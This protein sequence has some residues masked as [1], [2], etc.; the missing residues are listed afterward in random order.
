MTMLILDMTSGHFIEPETDQQRRHTV[1]SLQPQW[2]N[3]ETQL[4]VLEP[5]S[6]E[7]WKPSPAV[8]GAD[9]DWL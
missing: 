6:I 2:I 4:Q 9:I 1:E 3:Q 8:I 5:C 7:S